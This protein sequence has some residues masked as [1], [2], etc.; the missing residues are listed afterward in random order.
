MIYD[1]LSNILRYRGLHPNLDLAI[2]YVHNSLDQMGDH[3]DLLGADVYGNRFTYETVTEAETFYEAHAK[4]ADLQIMTNGVERVS[5]SDISVLTVDEAH[6]ERD[7]WAL[8]GREE[9]S[10]LLEPGSF[11][12]VLPGDAHKLK[13]C[14]GKPETVTK[15]VFKIRVKD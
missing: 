1:K 8:S 10:V 9:V 7:F 3:V 12:L 15:A 13:M 4:F 2:E 14:V 6:P 5:V 11:L